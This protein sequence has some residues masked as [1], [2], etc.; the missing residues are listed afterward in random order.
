MTFFSSPI[1][2]TCNQSDYTNWEHWFSI[3]TVT[4]VFLHTA[5]REAHG[6]IPCGETLKYDRKQ[7]SEQQGVY[8]LLLKIPHFLLCR[9][10]PPL[11]YSLTGQQLSNFREERVTN[12]FPLQ[13][14]VVSTS[15]KGTQIPWHQ[16]WFCPLVKERKTELLCPV[17]NFDSF[18]PGIVQQ[19]WY[20]HRSGAN[21][22]YYLLLLALTFPLLLSVSKT[23]AFCSFKTFFKKQ[24]NK[25]TLTTTNPGILGQG[26]KSKPEQFAKSTI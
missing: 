7:T 22:S 23:E 1:T 11:S 10:F 2:C 20:S 9:T 24:A 8:M 17:A 4:P 5:G 3:K 18:Y 14:N 6:T 25:K 26:E 19:T 16:A 21:L 12:H 15:L 13:L